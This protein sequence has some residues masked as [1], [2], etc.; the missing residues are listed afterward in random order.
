M[1]SLDFNKNLCRII[2]FFAAA[3]MLVAGPVAP[4]L[5]YADEKPGDT[6]TNNH[7]KNNKIHITA[8]KLFSDNDADYAEFIG[9]VRASQ[10]DTVIT[11]DRLKIFYKATSGLK[12]T[13]A[14]GEE[15][16]TKIVADGNV[17]I[18]FDNRVAVTP[19]AVYN[20]QTRILVLSGNNSK[21]VS[22]DNSISGE[23]ITI[24]RATGRINVE[25]GDKKR[26]EAVLYSGEKGLK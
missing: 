16:I 18:N 19:K 4:S 25:S 3:F 15:S 17:K 6:D 26:V 9:N 11:A 2:L 24:D 7:A 8:D 10:E 12:G 5:G 14:I 22:G 20:T 13:P 23:K 1:R 21:I